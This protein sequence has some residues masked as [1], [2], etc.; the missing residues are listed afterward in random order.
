MHRTTLFS[1]RGIIYDR[2]GVELAW[3]VPGSDDE[4][5]S[6]RAY[7]RDPGLAHVLGFVRYPRRDTS[8]F[9]WRFNF[10]GASGAELL[11]DQE[12]QGIHGV[13]LVEVDA[14]R[15]IHS[16]GAITEPVD[17]TN[18]HLTIDGPLQAELH[19]NMARMVNEFSYT[20][21]TAIIM[22]I[23]EGDIIALTSYP[24]FDPHVISRGTDTEAIRRYFE[25][26]TKPSLNRAV[27]G[28]YTPGSIVKPFI[29]LG[30]LQEDIITPSTTVSSTGRIEIPNPWNPA[31]PAVFRDWRPE[32]H[33][34]TDIYHAV[35]DSVNTFFYVFGGGFQGRQGIGISKIHEYLTMFQLGEPTS[36]VLGAGPSGVIPHPE[37]KRRVFKDGTWRVGDT[38]NTVIGQ[39]G[40]QVTPMQVMRATAALANKGTLVNPRLSLHEPITLTSVHGISAQNYEIIHDAMRQTVTA[41]TAQILNVPYVQAAVKTGTAQT[42]GNTRVNAWSIGFWPVDNP[43]Y[44]YTIVMEEGPARDNVGSTW[45]IRQTFDWIRDHAPQYFE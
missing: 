33:G 25:D 20:G 30:M 29:A 37:W 36:F 19:R 31:Q 4:P 11:Y 41:G 17:G 44:A 34:A 26:R 24:E 27:S 14:R 1:E 40:M 2:H 10:E 21:G 35:A 39:F 23:Q 12:L 15:I 5:F 6:Y 3:N 8:G 45:A 43:R 16:E 13:K 38:Y 18:V 32:G 22:D 7:Y 42:R 28:L 9:F